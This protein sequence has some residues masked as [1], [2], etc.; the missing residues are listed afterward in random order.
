M[1]EV[2]LVGIGSQDTAHGR[3]IETEESSAEGREGANGVDVVERLV[4]SIKCLS[5]H[6]ALGICLP[7]S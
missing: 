4:R 1:T 3:D 2:V 6:G 5:Q 7:S